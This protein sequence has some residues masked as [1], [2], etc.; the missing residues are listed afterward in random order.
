MVEIERRKF[1]RANYKFSV[2]LRGQHYWTITEEKNLGEGGMFIATE[3]LEPA[4]SRVDITFEFG[5]EKKTVVSIEGKVAWTRQ[6]NT[7]DDKGDV[8]PAGMGIEFI[9]IHPAT[10]KNFIN[11]MISFMREN[12]KNK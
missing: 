4:G 8:K 3:K 5:S 11:E 10:A 2:E 6:T 9:K 12:E 1:R 7:V